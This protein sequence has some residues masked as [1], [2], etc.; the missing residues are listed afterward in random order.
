MV[1]TTC[2]K[3]AEGLAELKQITLSH[4]PDRR[5]GAPRIPEGRDSRHGVGFAALLPPFGTASVFRTVGFAPD[6]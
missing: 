6:T 1:F 3:R 5:R 4:N 2:K